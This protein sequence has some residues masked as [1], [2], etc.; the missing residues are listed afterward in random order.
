MGTAAPALVT[1]LEDHR[2]LGNRVGRHVV[3]DLL[4]QGREQFINGRG[5][6]QRLGSLAGHLLIG[7]FGE[8]L[9]SV[10]GFGRQQFFQVDGCRH[11]VRLRRLDGDG[12]AFGNLKLETHDGFVNAAD[13]FH[14]E[15]AVAQAFAVKD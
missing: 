4:F 12:A 7:A 14:I 2:A 9:G 3:R 11:S 6:L 5:L 10:A 15:R 1:R 8:P 13:L